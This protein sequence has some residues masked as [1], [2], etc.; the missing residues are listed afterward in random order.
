MKMNQKY[1][2]EP[3]TA[4]SVMYVKILNARIQALCWPLPPGGMHLG[5]TLANP[6]S[7]GCYVTTLYAG[8]KRSL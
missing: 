6:G 8:S 3:G 2:T 7:Y 4:Y 5:S 1:N